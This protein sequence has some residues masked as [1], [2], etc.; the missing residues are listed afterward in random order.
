[1]EDD[2]RPFASLL[3]FLHSGDIDII[4]LIQESSR[5]GH[6]LQT[7]QELL[8]RQSEF[9]SLSKPS[10]LLVDDQTHCKVFQVEFG[11]VTE[12]FINDFAIEA[13]LYKLVVNSPLHVTLLNQT[14]PIRHL[15]S[16]KVIVDV[17]SLD[18]VK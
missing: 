18:E 5:K 7:S 11:L 6:L 4:Y 9:I 15:E 8:F 10:E 1:M 17:T 14:I 2:F 13:N 12:Y 16:I 3:V